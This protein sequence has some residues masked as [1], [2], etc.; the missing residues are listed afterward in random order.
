MSEWRPEGMP[1]AYEAVGKIIDYDGKPIRGNA[2]AGFLDGY[3]RAERA[4]LAALR[5]GG[6]HGQ[7][8]AGIDEGPWIVGDDGTYFDIADVVSDENKKGYLVFIPDKE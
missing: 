7:Y 6:V 1:T 8:T 5:E 3:E 4:M 2:R